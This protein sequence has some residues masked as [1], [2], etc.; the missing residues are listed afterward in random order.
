MDWDEYA[1]RNWDEVKGKIKQQWG[2]LTD[3]DVE[4]IRGRRERLIF[5]IQQRYVMTYGSAWRGFEAW[6]QR[7]FGGHTAPTLH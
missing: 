4:E 1:R 5:K 6:R 2:G 3:D 7:N